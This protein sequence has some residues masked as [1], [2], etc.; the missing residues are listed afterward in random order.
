MF[1]LSSQ[2]PMEACFMEVHQETRFTQV[3]VSNLVSVYREGRII[4]NWRNNLKWNMKT[5]PTENKK[6]TEDTETMTK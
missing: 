1:S 4:K 3:P 6:G 5:K 2:L